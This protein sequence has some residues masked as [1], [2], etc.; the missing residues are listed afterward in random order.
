MTLRAR[1]PY[2]NLDLTAWCDGALKQDEGW[3]LDGWAGRIGAHVTAFASSPR[4]PWTVHAYTKGMAL[5]EHAYHAKGTL[6]VTIASCLTG[7]ERQQD[8]VAEELTDLGWTP[9]ELVQVAAQ[10]GMAVSRG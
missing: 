2:R 8:I 3:A 6:A 5:R 7:I 9:D 4:G 10:S 1:T